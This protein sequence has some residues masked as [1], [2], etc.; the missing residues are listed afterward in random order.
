MEKILATVNINMG[1]GPNNPVLTIKY[2][3]DVPRMLQDFIQKYQLPPETY[4]I[5]REKI[6]QDLAHQ[7]IKIPSL[8]KPSEKYAA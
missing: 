6:E 5:I 7:N 1:E 2:S 8:Q 4:A 3:T